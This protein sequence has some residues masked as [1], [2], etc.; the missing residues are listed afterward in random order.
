LSIASAL[1][2]SS[3]P[4]VFFGPTQP[5]CQA[6]PLAESISTA[7]W[8]SSV[9]L[10]AVPLMNS[11]LTVFVVNGPGFMPLNASTVAVTRPDGACQPSTGRSL[12]TSR[13]IRDQSGADDA[14]DSVSV[15]GSL[16]LLPIQ[17]PTASAGRWDPS[18]A[19]GSRR[20]DVA[21]VVRRAG[22]VRGRPAGPA[23]V[24]RPLAPERVDLGVGVAGQDVG[25]DVGRLAADDLGRLGLGD[26]RVGVDDVAV[27]VDDLEDRRP[28]HEDPAVG[29]R[30][31]GAQHVD[32]VGLDRADA[33]RETGALPGTT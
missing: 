31:V 2:K 5:S 26:G 16:L 12:L 21:V 6:S 7:W 17:T 27:R 11:S 9:S 32:R 19:P 18:A 1:L 30:A 29:D 10:G 4:T 33:H 20:H 25:D 24:D 3:A 23:V 13:M 15:L 8:K 28:R 14:S 22:L